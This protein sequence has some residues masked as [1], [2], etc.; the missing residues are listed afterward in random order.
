MSNNDQKS[1]SDYRWSDVG[2]K[3]QAIQTKIQTSQN[4]DTREQ[5]PSDQNINNKT[6]GN[7]QKLGK[8]ED[9]NVD[10][11]TNDNMQKLEKLE[12]SK[13]LEEASR[14]LEKL[15]TSRKLEK[16]KKEDQAITK[17]DIKTVIKIL[18][19]VALGVVELQGIMPY[20][21]NEKGR[22]TKRRG[23]AHIYR[24][25]NYY[26]VVNT[27]KKE[28]P[29][30]PNDFD[31][32]VYNKERVFDDLER[33]SDIINVINDDKKESLFI[34]VSHEGTT[35]FSKESVIF[36]GESKTYFNVYELRFRSA[37][38]GHQYR[39]TEYQ[40]STITAPII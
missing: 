39:V 5:N 20:M 18:Q 19:Q 27:I 21:Y 17:S 11:E 36:P 13:R 26:D 22:D 16:P 2:E 4:I 28:S 35:T 37:K 12:T 9:Q 14:K 1:D 25:L 31:S 23:R 24:F 30:D 6:N 3:S 7:G 40:I 8:L 29:E 34:I 15:E 33:Y 38:K 32:P 10:N